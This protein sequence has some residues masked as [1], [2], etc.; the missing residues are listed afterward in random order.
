MSSTLGPEAIL[1]S[2]SDTCLQD[3]CGPNMGSDAQLLKYALLSTT[4]AAAQ[5]APRHGDGS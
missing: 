5:P 1:A 2:E 3:S 4:S